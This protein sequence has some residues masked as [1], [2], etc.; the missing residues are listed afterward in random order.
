[1]KAAFINTFYS[2]C[3][4]QPSKGWDKWVGPRITRV[5]SWRKTCFLIGCLSHNHI[6]TRCIA[7]HE[8]F[9]LL[10]SGIKDRHR[11]TTTRMEMSN[12]INYFWLKMTKP[13]S[14]DFREVQSPSTDLL[15][16]ELTLKS[17]CWTRCW[18]VLKKLRIIMVSSM[19]F[20]SKEIKE[21]V[22]QCPYFWVTRYILRGPSSEPSLKSRC[23]KLHEAHQLLTSRTK[24][25]SET[26]TRRSTSTKR[27]ARSEASKKSSQG[28][29]KNYWKWLDS[30]S[31][32]ETWR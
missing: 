12:N 25:Q 31:L 5:H 10:S 1:M 29:K 8:A 13:F 23:T 20:Y 4:G 17:A 11:D 19:F 14:S 32:P 2:A 30:S 3:R 24:L 22:F 27:S 6:I 9:Q 15:K 21:V 26:S 28:A 18:K 7:I 16:R